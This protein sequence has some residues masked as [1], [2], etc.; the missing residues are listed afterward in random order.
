MGNSWYAGPLCLVMAAGHLA[1]QS[2]TSAQIH[3]VVLDQESGKA[4][5]DVKVS[6]RPEGLI[7]TTGANGRFSL[8]AIPF[9][10]YTIRFERLGYAARADTVRVGPGLPLDITVRLATSPIPLDPIGVTVRSGILEAE[11]FYERRA[12]AGGSSTFITAED[13]EGR[14]PAILTDV[15]YQVQS[16]KILDMGPGQKH[17]RFNRQEGLPT[18]RVFLPGCEPAV[19]LDGYRIQDQPSEP[20][21]RDFNRVDPFTVAGIE[22][23]VGANTPLRFKHTSCGAVLVWTKRGA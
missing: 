2:L 10:N 3:G 20:R 19:F 8:R 18:T 17:L 12:N 21:L 5:A 22:V 16:V 1:G 14:I 11:G 4:I 7:A 15:M 6:L 9:G 13:I 23:Y